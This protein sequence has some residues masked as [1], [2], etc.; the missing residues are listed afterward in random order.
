MKRTLRDK[1]VFL[2]AGAGVALFA[3]YGLLP[4]SFFGGVAGL[5][6]AGWLFGFPVGS[7]ILIRVILGVFMLLG[8]MG[9]G[10]LFVAGGCLIGW[11]AG[12]AIDS[13]TAP[14]SGKAVEKTK[15]REDVA[16][17]GYV[18]GPGAAKANEE[19]EG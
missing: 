17:D 14:E 9:S 3:V 4:G 11:L 18:T 15:A 2:G 13:M 7:S 5:Y 19:N 1:A 8:I 16:L 6:F 10:T 12:T